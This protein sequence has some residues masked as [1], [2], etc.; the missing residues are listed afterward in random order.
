M[1]SSSRSSEDV[2]QLIVRGADSS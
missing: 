1:K 2:A